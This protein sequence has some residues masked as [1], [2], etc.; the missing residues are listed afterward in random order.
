MSEKSLTDLVI[1]EWRY[2]NLISHEQEHIAN[3]RALIVHSIKE[4]QGTHK[5]DLYLNSS[6][7]W[8]LIEE[9]VNS[10]LEEIGIVFNGKPGSIW[11]TSHGIAMYWGWRESFNDGISLPPLS[12]ILNDYYKWQDET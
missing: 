4:W 3:Y 1:T 8:K 12:D 6:E 5:R 9:Y 2:N 10:L 7:A 11:I